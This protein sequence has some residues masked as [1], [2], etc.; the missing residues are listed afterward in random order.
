ML[1]SV[2]EDGFDRL[3]E[4]TRKISRN[5]ILQSPFSSENQNEFQLIG[6]SMMKM[7]SDLFRLNFSNEE[8]E[9]LLESIG[10]LRCVVHSDESITF[11]SD[12]IYE[13][14]QWSRELPLDTS[15]FGNCF[16]FST[17]KSLV[18]HA[19]IHELPW[20]IVDAGGNYRQTQLSAMQLSET[21]LFLFGT[22]GSLDGGS[23]PEFPNPVSGLVLLDAHGRLCDHNIMFAPSVPMDGSELMDIL[24]SEYRVDGSVD[25]EQIKKLANTA[26]EIVIASNTTAGYWGNTPLFMR[27]YELYTTYSRQPAYALKIYSTDIKDIK[28]KVSHLTRYDP[29]TGIP[30]R[31][32][33][34]RKINYKI[35]E[36]EGTFSLLLIRISE[37]AEIKERYGCRMGDQVLVYVARVMKEVFSDTEDVYHLREDEFCIL[38]KCQREE[39]QKDLSVSQLLERFNKPVTVDAQSLVLSAEIGI[40]RYP[41]DGQSSK[42]L[43]HAASAALMKFNE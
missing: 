26:E 4:S 19:L 43:L 25:M 35:K 1:S 3:L 21:S 30:N 28:N 40:A 8:L 37:L 20:H 14:S 9:N 13:I 2:L 29:L 10:E 27:V 41:E 11:P 39:M 32:S 5:I 23:A 33:L 15:L 24:L 31:A 18:R 16:S 7:Q 38:C 17:L 22:R 34:F 6:T 12:S 36:E 42:S